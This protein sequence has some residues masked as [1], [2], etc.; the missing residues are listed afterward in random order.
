MSTIDRVTVYN[1]PCPCNKGNVTIIECSPDHPF[2]RESQTWYEG[3]LDCEKCTAKYKI[4]QL[5][6]ENGRRIIIKPY[7]KTKESIY[8]I[9]IDRFCQGLTK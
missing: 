8:L 9:N 5:D 3:K 6:N 7:D 4:D 2:V 1:K